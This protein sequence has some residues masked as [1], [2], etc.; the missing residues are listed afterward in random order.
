VRAK[1]ARGPV[2]EA[3]QSVDN[4]FWSA[5]A[6][7]DRR[8]AFQV[9]FAGRLAREKG[10]AVLLR[11]WAYSGLSAPSAALVLVGGGPIRARAVATGA[12]LRNFPTG[13]RV[14]IAS[15]LR[16]MPRPALIA[17]LALLLAAPPALADATRNKILREC[18]TGRL[19]GDY[20]AREIRDARNNIPDDLDQYTDCRDV[21]TRALLSRAGADSGS[22]GGG[23]GGGGTVGGTGGG[24]GGGGD[25]A[26]PLTPSTDADRQ[27][28]E[29]ASGAPVNVAGRPVTPGESAFRNDLP[30]P[31]LVLLALLAA[32]AVA[33]LAPQLRKRAP[34]PAAIRRV[35]PGRSG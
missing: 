1:G 35:I 25:S 4:A 32:A 22:G 14:V 26:A 29:Q 11:A 17:L 20:T 3:P 5:P 34:S 19:T 15:V 13:S 12:A 7:P 6:T 8:A 24:G 33:G 30:A 31:L 27:A 18:Q 10:V 21:L 2:V 23:T 16:L 28:L 9:M